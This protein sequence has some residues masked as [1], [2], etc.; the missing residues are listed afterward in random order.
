MQQ[1]M[2]KRTIVGNL[3][4]WA[5]LIF[6]AVICLAL[7]CIRDDFAGS[8]RKIVAYSIYRE[9]FYDEGGPIVLRFYREGETGGP[10]G[11]AKNPIK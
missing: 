11:V 4:I 8:G 1:I 9:G 6:V 5:T 2:Q 7:G 10:L 3:M